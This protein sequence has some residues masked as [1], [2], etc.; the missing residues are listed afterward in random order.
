MA[1]KITREEFKQKFGQGAPMSAPQ[2]QGGMN[3]GISDA[4]HGGIDQAKAGFSQAQNASNPLQLLEGGSKLAAGGINAAFSPLAPIFKPVEMGVNY[5]ADKISNSPSVQK[6][7]MS[8][9]GQTTSRIT[10]DIGNVNTI[11][12]GVIGL[13]GG[14]KSAAKVGGAVID[15]AKPAIAGT[16]RILKAGGESSYGLTTP[17]SESTARAMQTYKESTPNLVSRIKNTVSGETKGKPITEANTAARYGLMG[18]EQEIGVQAGRYMK[19]VWKNKVEPALTG[20]KGTLDMKKFFDVVQNE[21]KTSTAELSRR[22][23]LNEG[24]DA[25]RSQYNKVG[26]VSLRKLQ[27]YKEGWAKTLPESSFKGKPIAGA[28]KEV[29]QLAS[30][31]AREFIYDNAPEGIKQDYIDYGNLKSIREAGIKSGVG[32]LA[33]KSI[34]R[35]AWQFVMDKAVTP[36]ATVLGKILYKTGEGLE[37]IGEEGAKNVGDIVGHDKGIPNKQGGFVNFGEISKSVDNTDKNIMMSFVDAVNSGKTP[38]KEI[39]LQAQKIAD[40][41]GLESNMGSNLSIAKE[42]NKILDMERQNTKE[43]LK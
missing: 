42:F 4:F 25:L 32:D 15:S 21:I 9:A 19:D 3:L 12:Q 23:D 20:T 43:T 18:T 28:L 8:P 26:K 22:N 30:N 6:F 34:S 29:K 10:E 35:S 2:P 41:M 24:L 36:V 38:S 5:A 40:T 37:F 31:K 39:M 33:K 17:P 27:D 1:I 14:A 7:A 11:A 13:E 16:G